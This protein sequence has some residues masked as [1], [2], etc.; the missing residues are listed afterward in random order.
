MIREYLEKGQLTV[1]TLGRGTA[2]LDAGTPESLHEASVFVR[3]TEI[4]QGLKIACPEEV[5]Y[6]MG[7]ISRESLAKLAT[8]APN[9]DYRVYLASLLDR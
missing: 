9:E 7:F 3:T 8:H 2:W 1:E 5:A 6:H 4:R